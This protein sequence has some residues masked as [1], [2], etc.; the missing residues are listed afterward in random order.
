ML[1]HK[2]WLYFQPQSSSASPAS[3]LQGEGAELVVWCFLAWTLQTPRQHR[4]NIS[5]AARVASVA[6]DVPAN[7]RSSEVTGAEVGGDAL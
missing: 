3:G 4:W 7:L 5:V 2:V 6:A 1:Y